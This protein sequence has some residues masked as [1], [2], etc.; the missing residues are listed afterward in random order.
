MLAWLYCVVMVFFLLALILIFS[1][2]AKRLA[3]KSVSNMT[4]LV[5]SGTLNLN[6][7]INDSGVSDFLFLI[8]I[9]LS[10]FVKGR[11]LCFGHAEH[12]D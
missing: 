6:Q 2:L 11:L 5:S 12:K 9:Y 3:G 7:S 1:V 4:Y 10:T 8:F